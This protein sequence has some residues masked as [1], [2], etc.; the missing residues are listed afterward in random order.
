ALPP[1]TS[2]MVY[3]RALVFV[4]A[5][6][7]AGTVTL[8]SVGE[9]MPPYAGVAVGMS[10]GKL[11]LSFTTAGSYPVSTVTVPRGSWHCLD[12]AVRVSDTDGA[13]TLR[14]DGAQVLAQTG[15]D[16]RP[17][18]GISNGNAGILYL[19]PAGATAEARF[20]EVAF[21]TSPLSCY[22]P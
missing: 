5:S 4:P 8:L 3:L 12:L 10:A 13:A 19:A 2:G 1:V 6:V 15:L 21:G 11:Q 18:G 20:D 17:V 7:T 16:T 9:A 14:M 22:P